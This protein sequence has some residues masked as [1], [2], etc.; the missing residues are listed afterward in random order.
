MI[1]CPKPTSLCIHNASV[2]QYLPSDFGKRVVENTFEKE[3]GEG[4]FVEAGATPRGA[5]SNHDC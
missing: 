3:A 1:K 4:G 2:Y 5:S